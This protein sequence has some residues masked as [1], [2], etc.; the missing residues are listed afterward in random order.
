MAFLTQFE[1]NASSQVAPDLNIAGTA[2]QARVDPRLIRLPAIDATDYR[3]ARLSTIEE[4]RKEEFPRLCRT[5]RAYI[6]W[7]AVWAEAARRLPGRSQSM[8]ARSGSYGLAVR[9]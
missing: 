4:L 6:V 2:S 8:S 5:I 7:H 1:R 3:F 9:V